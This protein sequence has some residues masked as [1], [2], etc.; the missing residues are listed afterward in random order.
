MCTP[1]FMDQVRS[2]AGSPSTQQI[3]PGIP[4]PGAGVDPTGGM[5]GHGMP[6]PGAPAPG[7]PPQGRLPTAAA[8]EAAARAQQQAR[9]RQARP[10]MPMPAPQPLPMQPVPGAVPA[11]DTGGA[12]Q[13]QLSPA[14]VFGPP[15]YRNYPEPPSRS[16]PSQQA[17]EQLAQR[18]RPTQ[19]DM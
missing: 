15:G 12:P 16:F 8:S 11:T 14:M 7:V 4:M 6:A 19:G 1:Q 9:A 17:Q 2:M 13:S 3:A 18:P 10:P 5:A